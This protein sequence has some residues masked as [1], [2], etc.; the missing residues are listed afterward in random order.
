MTHYLLRLTM[1]LGEIVAEAHK[2]LPRAEYGWS[3]QLRAN[4]ALCVVLSVCGLEDEKCFR[5]QAWLTE[6]A[7]HEDDREA[8]ALKEAS[9]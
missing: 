5:Y 7:R 6:K 4:R 1:P 8:E 9:R 2:D 3:R